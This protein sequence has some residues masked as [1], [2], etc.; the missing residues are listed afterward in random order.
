MAEAWDY[1]IIGGGT[2]GCVLANRLS[3]V[4]ANKVLLIEAG[5]DTPPDACPADILDPY[6]LAYGNPLYRWPLLGHALTAA[7]STSA[8][9]LH[10]RVM[11]GGSSIMGMIMLRGIP[12]DYDGWE[13]LGAIDWGWDDVLPFFRL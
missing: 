1:I 4:S 3:A 5:V 7:K 12:L 6:P 8:P 13:S 10:A 9:V 2:A 11:G